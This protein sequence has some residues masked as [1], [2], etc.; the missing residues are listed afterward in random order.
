LDDKS[1][2]SDDSDKSDDQA[3]EEELS[4]VGK[5]IEVFVFAIFSLKYFRCFGQKTVYYQ[6]KVR[7]YSLH[8]GRHRV[9]YPEE[10]KPDTHEYLEW[11]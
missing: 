11:A 6:G 10:D 8:T 4:L 7:G 1:E 9:Q 5:E 3:E 2:S